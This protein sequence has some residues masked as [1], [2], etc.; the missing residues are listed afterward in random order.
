MTAYITI[1]DAETDPEAPLTSELAKKWRDN[2]IAIAEGDSSVPANLLPSV[3]LGTIVTTS[4]TTQT[5][6][7]LTLTGYKF[8]ILICDG[9]G[10]APSATTTV[11]SVAGREIYTKTGSQFSN[12]RGVI[13]INLSTGVGIGTATET[14]T[15][16]VASP[17]IIETTLSTAA[18]SISVSTNTTAFNA[19]SVLVYGV[20]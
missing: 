6:S 3:L 9:V 11:F 12:L 10:N 4:G 2:P 13:Q 1:T 15:T 14:T 5:L 19:G 17:R 20:K 7:G 8:L 16:A 18:T